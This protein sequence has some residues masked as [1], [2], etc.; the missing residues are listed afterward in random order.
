M[1]LV[2][3]QGKPFNVTVIQVYA[4]ATDAEEAEAD[5]SY[6]YLYDLLELIPKKKMSFS[7]Q[8]TGMQ[9]L[10]VRRYLE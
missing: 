9:K 5:Q 7:S 2:H 10:E 1:I 4:P 8:G 3:F 6:E